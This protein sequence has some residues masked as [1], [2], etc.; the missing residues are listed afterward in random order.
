MSRDRLYVLA[1]AAAL[2]SAPGSALAQRTQSVRFEVSFSPAVA[3]I[4]GRTL[5]GRAYV[6]VSRGRFDAQ[7]YTDDKAHLGH[8]L[9]RDVSHQSAVEASR[10]PVAGAQVV[11]P[12]SAERQQSP[13]AI[14]R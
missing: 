12:A 10:A 13:V 4:T 8:A 14:A 11:K 3:A 7:I 6:A 5:T 9:S 1:I 2:A